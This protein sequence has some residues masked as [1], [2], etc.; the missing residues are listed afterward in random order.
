MV[1]GCGA[2]PKKRRKEK[3]VGTAATGKRSG[4]LQGFG[5]LIWPYFVPIL[6]LILFGGVAS[7]VVSC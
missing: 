3:S 1:A 4:G 7:Y 2:E 5:Q 6:E